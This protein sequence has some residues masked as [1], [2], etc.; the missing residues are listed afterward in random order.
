MNENI[1]LGGDF[2]YAVN[3]LDKKGGKP[4]DENKVSL[5]KFQTL[6]KSNNLV[7]SWRFKNP[8][9]VRFTSQKIQSRFDYLFVS[10]RLRMLIQNCVILPNTTSDHSA[11]LLNITF[12]EDSPKRGPGFWKFHNSL[13]SDTNCVELLA[14]LLPEFL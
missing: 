6:I 5:V 9:S 10:Q 3:S 2:N 12:D 13:L 8:Q 4:F 1:V 11:V 14:L 7:D